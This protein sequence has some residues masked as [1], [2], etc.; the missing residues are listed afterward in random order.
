MDII[1]LSHSLQEDAVTIVFLNVLLKQLGLPIPA[2]PTLLLAGSL[3]AAPMELGKILVAAVLASVVADWLWYRAGKLFGYRLLAGLCRLSINP[4]SCVSQTEGRFMRWGVSSLIVAK[5]IPGFSTVAPPIAGALR[6]PQLGFL[7]AAGLGAGLWAGLPLA[8]GWVLK[9]SVQAVIVALDQNAGLALLVVLLLVG[10]WFG[11]KLWQKY[12][13][14]RLSAIPHITPDE[15]ITALNA[16]KPPLV[17]DLRGIAMSGE[18]G[19]ISG[20]RVAQIGN[21]RAAVA[22][23]PKDQP[24]VTICACPDDAGAIQAAHDLLNDGFLSVRPLRGGYDAWVNA[25]AADA[26]ER[27]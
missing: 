21:L 18:T 26:A 17:L 24:I 19:P 4:G 14:R 2:V 12:Q 10:S 5:F 1:R 25:T 15:L 13:F 3:S 9:D 20:C 8:V 22:D 11:W 27:G 7:V 16:P 6:M 23:W